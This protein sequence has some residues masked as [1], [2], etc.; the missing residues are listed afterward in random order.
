QVFDPLV[1]A[2]MLLAAGADIAFAVA[3]GSVLVRIG[4]AAQ[5]PRITQS[6]ADR[7][8]STLSGPPPSANVWL[9]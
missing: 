9:C 4:G 2:Q 8:R 5:L 7:L 3:V 6:D 1:I